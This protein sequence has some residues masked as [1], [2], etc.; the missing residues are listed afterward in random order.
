MGFGL[1]R[2]WRLEELPGEAI[3]ALATRYPLRIGERRQD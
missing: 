3:D 1:H 2:G